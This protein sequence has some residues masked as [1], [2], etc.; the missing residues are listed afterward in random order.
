MNTER[1]YLA[2]L[3]LHNINQMMNE[4][5]REFGRSAADDVML[6]RTMDVIVE[7]C[8]EF[9]D[10]VRTRTWHPAAPDTSMLVM[11][12]I[13]IADKHVPIDGSNQAY[14]WDAHDRDVAETLEAVGTF[15]RQ[16]SA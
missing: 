8:I 6:Y 11:V 7:G 10:N 2:A 3:R 16:E 12:D 5:Q 13:L 9:G 14:W 1:A 4:Y 15:A